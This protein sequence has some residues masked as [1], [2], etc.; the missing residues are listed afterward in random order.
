[1]PK[2]LEITDK[3][4][5]AFEAVEPNV[6]NYTFDKEPDD[7]LSFVWSEVYKKD[8]ALPAHLANI[9]LAAYL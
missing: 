9:A 4:D 8:E 2:N 5:K 1:M 7:T 3:I 6:I